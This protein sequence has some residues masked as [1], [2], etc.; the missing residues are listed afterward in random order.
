MK[1]KTGNIN[2]F[3]DVPFNVYQNTQYIS[4]FKDDIKR[5]LGPKN[6]LIKN[7]GKLTYF[8]AYNDQDLPVGRITA[9][10]HE[11]SNERHH[12]KRGYFGFFDCENKLETA[13]LLLA[14]A[15]KWNR[16]QG[17]TEMMGNFNLTAMQQMGVMVEGFE[18]QPYIDQ[19]YSPPHIYQLLEACGYERSFPTTTF[20]FD[21]KNF[22]FSCLED[23]KVRS[24]IQHPDYE[25]KTFE[26]SKLKEQMIFSCDLLNEGFKNNPM[27]VPLTHEEFIFQAKDMSLIID[28]KI[29]SFVKYKGEPAG[30]FITIPDLN[31]ILKEVRSRLTFSFPF[32]LFKLK[33]H[34]KRCLLIF[35]SVKPEQHSK[36]LGIVMIYHAIK[37]MHERG[38][39]TLGVTWI[40]DENKAP[41]ALIKKTGATAYHRLYLFGKRL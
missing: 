13:Q 37:K 38:Y 10:I 28:E 33:R 22:D 4:P 32:K 5:F 23:D 26:K 31:P 41:L 30:V 12:L 18:K 1:I 40:S 21:I 20:E 2:D 34:P 15:E 11:A 14:A 27:F 29:T 6:P 35:A 24:L 3:F 7:F 9:H 17:M 25:W 16:D 36:G 8:V 19:I 39:E